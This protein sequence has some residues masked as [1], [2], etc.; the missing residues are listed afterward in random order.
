MSIVV[1]GLGTIGCSW[2]ALF[3]SKGWHVIAT[4]PLPNASDQLSFYLDRTLPLLLE[5]GTSTAVESAKSNIH[6][7]PELLPFHL[8]DVTF[9][10]E[11]STH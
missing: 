9:L 1:V 10:Q 11:V 7:V 3:L 4:D 2:V 8:Q 5:N 6:F